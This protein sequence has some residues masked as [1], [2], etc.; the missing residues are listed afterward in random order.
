MI[1]VFLS[2]FS[3]H[4][5]RH[6]IVDTFFIVPCNTGLRYSVTSVIQLLSSSLL[7]LGWIGNIAIKRPNKRYKIIPIRISKYRDKNRDK[8]QELKKRLIVKMKRFLYGV[9]LTC[10]PS[11]HHQMDVDQISFYQNYSLGPYIALQLHL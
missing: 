8:K 1:K 7:Q 10:Y 11:T 5:N 2:A 6:I 3:E 9:W 4:K